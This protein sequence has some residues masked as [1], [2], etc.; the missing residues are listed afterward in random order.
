MTTQGL[1][2]YRIRAAIWHKSPSGPANATE[3]TVNPLFREHFPIILPT[4]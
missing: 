4:P 3:R 1:V 2:K